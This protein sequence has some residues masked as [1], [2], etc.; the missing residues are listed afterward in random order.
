M[1][2]P[3]NVTVVLVQSY[4]S[5]SKVGGSG[6]QSV[7]FFACSDVRCSTHDQS[8]SLQF[9]IG[10]Y[11]WMINLGVDVFWNLRQVWQHGSLE[12][13]YLFRVG[14]LNDVKTDTAALLHGIGPQHYTPCLRISLVHSRPAW[15]GIYQVTF[16]TCTRCEESWSGKVTL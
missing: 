4:R 11:Y 14:S 12:V 2:L 6:F 13:F 9:D 7:V 15:S 3:A 1:P 8:K 5:F 16:L 10:L